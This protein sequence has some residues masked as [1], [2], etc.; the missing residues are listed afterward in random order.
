MTSGALVLVAPWNPVVRQTVRWQPTIPKRA[1]RP[2]KG[3]RVVLSSTT[4]LRQPRLAHRC[5][6]C[7]TLV[8]PPDE[9]Y[10]A[11]GP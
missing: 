11:D 4:F 1:V 9:I 8:V 6:T 10:D 3:S 5:P 2:P 7:A